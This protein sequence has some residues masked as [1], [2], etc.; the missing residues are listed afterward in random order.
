M[1][2]H[3][4]RQHRSMRGEIIDFS[5]LSLQNQQQVALGNARMNAKGDILGEGGIILKTQE[6]V[7]AEWAAA[8]AM[9]Q[10]FTA[11]IK[12]EQPLSQAAPPPMPTPRAATL[13]DVE[14][15]TIQ[16][17]VGSGVITPTPKRKIAEKDD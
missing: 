15:P 16:E 12:S 17:L 6:Q 11:D 1:A 13:P 10:T 3:F 8:R 7:E 14:F 9:S 2:G 4:R 5:A